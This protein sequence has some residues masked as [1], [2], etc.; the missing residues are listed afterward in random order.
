ML[1]ILFLINLKLYAV[2]KLNLS[3]L[4]VCFVH[5]YY[6]DALFKNNIVYD[7]PRG[8]SIGVCNP[9]EDSRDQED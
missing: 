4:A 1:N 6:Q 9:V 7:Q 8:L 5:R 3:T 2:S